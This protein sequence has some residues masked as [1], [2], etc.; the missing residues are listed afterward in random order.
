MAKK[1]NIRNSLIYGS[2]GLSICGKQEG[3]SKQISGEILKE[4]AWN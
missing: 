2:Y 3:I 4:Y 1:V